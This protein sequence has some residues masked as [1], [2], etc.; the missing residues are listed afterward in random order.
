[1]HSKKHTIPLITELNN[2]DNK[3]KR[4]TINGKKIIEW[5]KNMKSKLFLGEY[6]E[7]AIKEN[8]LKL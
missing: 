3:L 8:Y 1:M 5:T 2:N 4:N 7:I 6:G